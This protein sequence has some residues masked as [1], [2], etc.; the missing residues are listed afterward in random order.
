[1]AM[2]I[3]NA[4]PSPQ[5]LKN[6]YPLSDRLIAMKAQRDKEIRDVFTGVSDKFLV[7]VGP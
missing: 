1:M 4:L 6:D 7:I 3:N 5:E 2:R